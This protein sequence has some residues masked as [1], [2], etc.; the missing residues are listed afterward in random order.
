MDVNIKGA[1][2][3]SQAAGRVMRKTVGGK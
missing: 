1:F 2:F 3:C